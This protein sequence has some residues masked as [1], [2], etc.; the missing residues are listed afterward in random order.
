MDRRGLYKCSD[1]H[2]LIEIP[3]AG[4]IAYSWLERE[5]ICMES[6]LS[7]REASRVASKDYQRLKSIELAKAHP[8]MGRY[9][10]SYGQPLKP[11]TA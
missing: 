11:K 10:N 3:E 2:D 6:G 9:P 4:F 7:E 8:D 5:A 1:E